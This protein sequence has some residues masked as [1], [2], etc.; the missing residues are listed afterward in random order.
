MAQE[1]NQQGLKAARE[2]LIKNGFRES[3]E[4]PQFLETHLYATK[5]ENQEISILVEPNLRAL[6]GE[7]EP[8]YQLWLWKMESPDT[9][10]S[11]LFVPL[12]MK[13]FLG[14]YLAMCDDIIEYSPL[15]RET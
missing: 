11:L 12:G 6:K 8:I 10:Q 14:E 5:P 1:K 2:W 13:R 3:A 7:N 4:I 15:D 9:R